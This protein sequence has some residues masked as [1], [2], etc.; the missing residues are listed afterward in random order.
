VVAKLVPD[1]LTKRYQIDI[2]TGAS[3]ADMA[4][5]ETGTVRAGRLVHPMNPDHTGI[6]IQVVRGDY[7]ED[8]GLSRNR[9]RLWDKADFAPSPHDIFQERLYCIQWITKESFHRGRQETFFASVTEDDLLRECRVEAIVAKNLVDWQTQGI[10]PDMRIEPGDKTDEPIRTRGWT[11]WH[12]LFNPRNLLVIAN[13]I[14]AVNR[15]VKPEHQQSVYFP[16]MYVMDR[17]SKLCHWRV[18]SL[19]RP[20]RAPSADGVENVFQNQ[21]LNT[22]YNYGA[23]SVA[24][25]D[26]TES[27]KLKSFPINVHTAVECVPA[28]KFDQAVDLFVTDPPYAE[29]I[30]YEEITEF[31]I[32]WFSSRPPI[33]FDQWVWDSRRELS[34]KGSDENFR[35]AMV[36]CYSQLVRKM[37]DNG[38]Q[39]VMFTHQDAD[40]WADLAAILWA[41]GLAV[42]TAWNVLTEIAKP[43]GDGNYVQSTVNLVLRKRH[44]S[45]NARRMEIEAEIEEA[46]GNHLKRLTA[47]NEKWQIRSGAEALYT[48]GD[49]TLAAYAAALQVVTNYSTIDRQA[50]DRDLYRRLEKGERTMLRDLIDYAASVANNL[51]VP[52][53][54]AKELWRDLEA[55]ER[56][57]VRMLDMEAKATVKVG[58]FQNFSRSFAYGNYTEVMGSAVAN[59]ASLAGAADFKG[60]ILSGE[61]FSGTQLRQV[62]FATWKTMEGGQRDPKRGVTILKTEYAADYWQRRQKLIAFAS[63]VALKTQR[64]RPDE[65]AAAGELAEA[66]RLDRV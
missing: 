39:V 32:S 36:A 8:D 10:V 6:E 57:Y 24:S 19:A 43:S 14:K 61:G 60:R 53:G 7:R 15:E 62:L 63:Y 48:D 35:R 58:D 66:L 50:L 33:P 9:L 47:L 27:L 42:S 13:F 22:F 12:H 5:A 52:E 38:M 1:H 51:L 37:P 40:V 11:H 56:F 65:S 28:D 2:R 59:A 4:E 41:A 26:F 23:R 30:R 29:A 25:L 54:F 64:T 46:V 3:A 34:V 16:L 45:I 55:A 21:A 44:K 49:L 18:G 31:F 17:S 20:G